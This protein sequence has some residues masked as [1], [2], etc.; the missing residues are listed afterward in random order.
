MATAL[1]LAHLHHRWRERSCPLPSANQQNETSHQ[2]N[3]R[4]LPFSNCSTDHRWAQLQVNCCCFASLQSKSLDSSTS[5]SP[6][7]SMPLS[8]QFL[9]FRPPTLVHCPSSLNLLSPIYCLMISPMFHIVSWTVISCTFTVTCV[10]SILTG[11]GANGIIPFL[12]EPL[13]SWILPKKL[14]S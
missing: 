9:S 1:G 10:L 13:N 8:R 7:Q 4:G 2:L 5:R 14:P 11:L 12:A 3:R 6:R